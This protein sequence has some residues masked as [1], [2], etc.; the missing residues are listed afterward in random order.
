MRN[1]LKSH[2]EVCHF[3][4]NKIQSSGR[5]NNV[6]FEGNKIYS[7]GHHFTMAEH[8]EGTN[9]VLFTSRSYSSSTGKHKSICRASIPSYLKI[10]YCNIDSLGSDNLKDF[11]DTIQELLKSQARAKTRNYTSSIA[12]TIENARNYVEYIT[13]ERAKYRMTE[14]TTKDFLDYLLKVE[15]DLENQDFSSVQK[16]IKEESEER[17]AQRI[18]RAE[19][20]KQKELEELQRVDQ[21]KNGENVYRSFKETYCRISEDG[22]FV[23]TS[24]SAKVTIKEAKTLINLIKHGKDIQG[25]KLS[26]YTVIGYDGEVLTVGCHKINTSEVERI[27]TIL[28][29]I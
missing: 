13:S 28:E 19:R 26:G 2:E 10:I 22:E 7:Y 23:E 24:R 12:S 21:W 20:E 14:D 5:S 9:I 16:L 18:K 6:F 15:T 29:T 1:V 4:A 8:V 11:K 27:G 25:L 3:W 17:K